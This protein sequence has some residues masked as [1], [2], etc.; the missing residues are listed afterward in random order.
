M[1][2]FYFVIPQIKKKGIII[3]ITIKKNATKLW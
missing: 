1:Y 2:K 3:Y